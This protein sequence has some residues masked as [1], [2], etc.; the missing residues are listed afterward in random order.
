[1]SALSL[2]R[3]LGFKRAETRGEGGE[4]A[5]GMRKVQGEEIVIDAAEL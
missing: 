1:M 4:R 5:Q 2:A 3:E